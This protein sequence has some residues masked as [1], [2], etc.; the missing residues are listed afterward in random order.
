MH[1][2]FLNHVSKTKWRAR[3]FGLIGIALG[4]IIIYVNPTYFSQYV[5]TTCSYYFFWFLSSGSIFVVYI[6]FLRMLIDAVRVLTSNHFYIM[7]KTAGK[8]D[9]MSAYIE[10]FMIGSILFLIFIVFGLFALQCGLHQYLNIETNFIV[11]PIE[12]SP[13][14][15]LYFN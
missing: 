8:F 9:L 4:V 6:I 12:P 1:E 13:T 3:F 2:H 15:G 10:A 11:S 7:N 5:V 14:P